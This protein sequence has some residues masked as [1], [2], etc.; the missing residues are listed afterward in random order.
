MDQQDNEQAYDDVLVEA[1][2]DEGD[3][4]DGLDFDVEWTDAR[5]DFVITLRRYLDDLSEE[6]ETSEDELI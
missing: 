6:E 5:A 2:G 3:D 1:W 4:F